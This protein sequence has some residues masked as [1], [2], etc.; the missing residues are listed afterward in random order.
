MLV[1]IIRA[2]HGRGSFHVTKS[3]SL[4]ACQEGDC[5]ETSIITM[6]TNDERLNAGL[7]LV[8]LV[9]G[10]RFHDLISPADTG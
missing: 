2:V 9:R 1:Y 3:M 7:Y 4:R 8:L 10:L 6:V 5:T